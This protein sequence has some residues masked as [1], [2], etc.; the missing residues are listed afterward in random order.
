MNRHDVADI[1][2]LRL[3]LLELLGSPHPCHDETHKLEAGD[4]VIGVGHKAAGWT[5]REFLTSKYIGPR[6]QFLDYLTDYSMYAWSGGPNPAAEKQAQLAELEEEKLRRFRK[7]QAAVFGPPSGYRAKTFQEFSPQN[8]EM[9]SSVA[10]FRQ[11]PYVFKS[12][13]EDKKHPGE[14]LTHLNLLVAGPP[15]T[16]KTHL[17]AALY[18]QSLSD[19][20]FRGIECIRCET[21]IRIFKENDRKHSALFSRYGDGVADDKNVLDEGCELLMIDDF[22]VDRSVYASQ[23]LIE[24]L[25]R[26]IAAGLSTV[27]TTNLSKAEVTKMLGPRGSSRLFH[28]CLVVTMVG[29]DYRLKPN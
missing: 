26:R 28:R 19:E 8:S 29:Y 24:I 9:E 15:G 27:L 11:W 16:G 20:Y 10:A 23:I 3:E 4:E 5:K 22:G 1:L 25:D 18:M 2:R 21:L 17:T 13:E 6:D 12:E 14:N 7:D